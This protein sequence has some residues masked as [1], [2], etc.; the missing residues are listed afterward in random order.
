MLGKV[1]KVYKNI[2]SKSWN[3]SPMLRRHYHKIESKKVKF[4]YHVELVVRILK[5][6]IIIILVEKWFSAVRISFKTSKIC[7]TCT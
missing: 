3:S 5:T 7:E 2:L 4:V 1:S 6:E